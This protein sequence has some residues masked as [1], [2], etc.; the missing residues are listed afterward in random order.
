MVCYL[1]EWIPG[2]CEYAYTQQLNTYCNHNNA[3]HIKKTQIKN[4]I[5]GET[6]TVSSWSVGVFF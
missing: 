4:K 3:I 1:L 5:C 2:W 6:N